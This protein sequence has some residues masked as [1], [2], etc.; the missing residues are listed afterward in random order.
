MSWVITASGPAS[1]GLLDQYGG[2]AAAYSLRNLSIYNAS[3]VVRVRRS[4][5]N[6]EQDFT[7][8]QVSDGSLAT[9][10]GAGNNGFVRTWYDQSGNNR[11]ATQTNTT[12]QPTI[13]S[14]GS[15]LLVNDK[16]AVN[17]NESPFLTST[18][19]LAFPFSAF[20]TVYPNSNPVSNLDRFAGHNVL[21]QLRYA[22]ARLGG[23]FNAELNGPVLT[24]A[25][26]HQNTW[27]AINNG[28][29]NTAANGSSLFETTGAFEIATSAFSL[30]RATVAAPFSGLIQ[31]GVVYLSDQST[32]RAAIEANINAHY[33]IY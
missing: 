11:N 24:G 27:L 14:N 16:P 25:A 31:E 22:S 21:G 18:L 9:W 8:T 19:Q 3:A 30:G 32:N 15:L 20:W 17:F 29:I 13:V 2:A 28:L 6:T 10:V 33:A 26:Q 12:L 5:D 7:A 1:L 4:S 23:W